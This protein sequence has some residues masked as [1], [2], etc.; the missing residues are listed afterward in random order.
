MR[1]LLTKVFIFGL[2]IGVGFGVSLPPTANK[3]EAH[4]YKRVDCTVVTNACA[5]Y[6]ANPPGWCSRNFQRN[7][8]QVSCDA[9]DNFSR[10]AVTCAVVKW[11]EMPCSDGCNENGAAIGGRTPKQ[12][13]V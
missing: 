1:Q 4:G 2:A 3:V 12:C 9:T 8:L 6:P 13:S 5:V 11:V 7:G 10:D